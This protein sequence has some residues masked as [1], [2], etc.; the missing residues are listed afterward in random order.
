MQAVKSNANHLRNFNTRGSCRLTRTHSTTSKI[1]LQQPIQYIR[2]PAVIVNH[3]SYAASLYFTAHRSTLPV[4]TL[5]ENK[6]YATQYTTCFRFCFFAIQQIL[7]YGIYTS[8]GHCAAS[9][10]DYTS[11]GGIGTGIDHSHCTRTAAFTN[12]VQTHA[13]TLQASGGE[14]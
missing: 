12:T 14:N 10:H 3:E 4:K 9:Q 8:G 6:H 7:G 2:F 11:V 1:T 5:Q 13:P